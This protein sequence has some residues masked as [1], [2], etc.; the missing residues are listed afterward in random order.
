MTIGMMRI[1]GSMTHSP[2]T[3][4]DFDRYHAMAAPYARY[5]QAPDAELILRRGL[6]E[7]AY[8]V[9]H[10]DPADKDE[11]HKETGDVLWY[12]DGI[13]DQRQLKLS[14][15]AALNGQR[16]Q[17]ISRFQQRA[18]VQAAFPLYRPGDSEP[19]LL[20]AQPHA[21]L[22]V[23]I[24]RVIDV[25][26]PKTDALWHH[27][28]TRPDLGPVI[29][30]ALGRLARFATVMQLSLDEAALRTLQKLESRGRQPHVI[31][32]AA[33]LTS[34]GRGRLTTYPIVGKLLRD[35]AVHDTE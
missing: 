9:L 21:D 33:T 14:Q 3:P 13:S 19:I 2:E 27:Y 7:E 20:D 35:V 25:L 15:L 26:N 28:V 4:L 22:T 12:L 10:T 32:A 5:C 11:L 31:D 18:M 24:L 8:E 23:A 6:L 1:V 16:G 29:Y 30:N 17:T 34:S